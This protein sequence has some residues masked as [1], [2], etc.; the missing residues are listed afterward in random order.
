MTERMERRPAEL[1]AREQRDRLSGEGGIC[2]KCTEKPRDDRQTPLRR[3]ARI[4]RE[5]GDR[6]PDRKPAEEVRRERPERQLRDDRVE[7]PAET[8]AE[9]CAEDR[10]DRHRRKAER[11]H[12]ASGHV[13]LG[14]GPALCGLVVRRTRLDPTRAL[15]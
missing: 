15:R 1:A 13:L 9:P 5:K 6:D 4:P 12:L 11:G 10:P 3:D 14:T 8:P 2:R 7:P